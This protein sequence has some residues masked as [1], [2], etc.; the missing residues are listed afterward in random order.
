M[1]TTSRLRSLD[2][3]RGISAAIVLFWHYGG[4]FHGRPGSYFFSAFYG[5][6]QAAVD[7]FFVISGFVLQHVY[8]ERLQNWGDL[9][10]FIVRRL[11]R[12]YPLH[13][14]TLIVVALLFFVFFL[15]GGVYGFVYLKNDWRH[16]VMNVLFMQYVGFQDGFSFN[17]P[18]WTISAEFWINIVFAALTIALGRVW[19]ARLGFVVVMISTIVLVCVHG[20]WLSM[21]AIGGWLEPILLRCAAG[22]F[23]G[24][25]T[26]EVW[27]L[28]E[29]NQTTANLLLV[30][31][32]VA[33]FCLMSVSRSSAMLIYVEA[34]IAVVAAPLLIFSAASSNAAD[35]IANTRIGKWVGA[36]SFS[37]Y[38]WHFPVAATMELLGVGSLPQRIIFGLFFVLTYA[39]AS[40]SVKHMEFTSQDA[41]NRLWERRIRGSVAAQ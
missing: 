23:A 5:N 11:A 13:L 24:V 7:V 4:Y 36:T 16:F 27:R 31:S 33:I 15:E 8:G 25:V 41:M 21:T 17:G 3:L 9:A 2:L 38:M 10:T 1:K 29:V 20:E 14:A 37:V 12:L 32:G 22:F 30:I 34:T 39:V 28:T 26:Y 35:K 40:L 19:S 18:S 6:G